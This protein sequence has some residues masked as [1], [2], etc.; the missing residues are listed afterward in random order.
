MLGKNYLK[1]SDL[2]TK[3]EQDFWSDLCN[4][5]FK[6]L[7]KL[8]YQNLGEGHFIDDTDS[9]EEE[10][11]DGFARLGTKRERVS[12]NRRES[13][14]DDEEDEGFDHDN[15][16]EQMMQ[17]M[18]SKQD[19]EMEAEQLRKQQLKEQQEKEEYEE[20]MKNARFNDN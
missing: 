5:D 14:D 4:R 1:Y 18:Q 11:D 3:A 17:E 7:E 2:I 6:R 10:K 19:E 13:A 8:A 20:A 12:A 16:M 9:E 15:F